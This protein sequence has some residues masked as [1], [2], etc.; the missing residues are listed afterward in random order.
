MDRRTKERLHGL[1]PESEFD[2]PSRNSTACR[3]WR[4]QKRHRRQAGL[5][6]LSKVSL[7]MPQDTPTRFCRRRGSSRLVSDL[8]R[9]DNET[10]PLLPKAWEPDL[11]AIWREAAAKPAHAVGLMHSIV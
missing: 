6:Q 8:A 5:L 4:F 1:R 3:R 10:N 7:T 2:S 9:R 11:S